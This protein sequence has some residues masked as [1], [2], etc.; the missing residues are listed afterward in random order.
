MNNFSQ[1]EAFPEAITSEGLNININQ[2][3]PLV[4]S[5]LFLM[6]ILK[7]IFHIQF[8]VPL[9]FVVSFMLLSSIVLIFLA[10]LLTLASRV[11]PKIFFIYVVGDSILLTFIIYYL[12]GITW[13]GF[14]FYSF[15]LVLNFLTF[16][17]K[18]AIFFT[19]WIIFLYSSLVLL[20][21][22]RI[23][24][25]SSLFLSWQQTPFYLP[26]VLTTTLGYLTIIIFTA[27]Y[28]RGFYLLYEKKILALK[29]TQE[30]LTREKASLEEMIGA[31]KQELEGEKKG[32]QKRIEERRKELTKEEQIL[33]ERA[34]ELKKFKQIALGREE[35]LKELSREL[36][37]LQQE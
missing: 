36:E 35:K 18:L 4:A 32:L 13:I 5:Y 17:R 11:I 2:R 9:F 21:Y 27:Y 28:G 1:L 26:Y 24:P 3:I 7:E 16:P 37:R 34:E 23:L 19:I 10:D 20:Q 22:S 6:L 30:I 25:F 29:E 8:P 31:R 15:Y 12:G 33:R 14:V